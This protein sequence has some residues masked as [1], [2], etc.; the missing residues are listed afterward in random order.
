MHNVQNLYGFIFPPNRYFEDVS[1]SSMA[2][3]IMCLMLQYNLTR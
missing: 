2:D 1:S 3:M